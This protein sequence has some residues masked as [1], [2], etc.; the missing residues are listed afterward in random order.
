MSGIGHN[1]G[2]TME[3]GRGWRRYAWKRARAE[4]DTQAM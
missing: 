2:P 1:G 4:K 3:K